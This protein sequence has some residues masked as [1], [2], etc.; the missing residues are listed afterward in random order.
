MSHEAGQKRAFLQ[1][2]MQADKSLASMQRETKLENPS[3]FLRK[4]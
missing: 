4:K 2:S 1:P 3:K